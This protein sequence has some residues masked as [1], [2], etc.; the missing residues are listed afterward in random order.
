M[1]NQTNKPFETF[2]TTTGMLPYVDHTSRLIAE[3]IWNYQ[4]ARIDSLMMEYCPDDMTEDQLQEYEKHQK[5][6]KYDITDKT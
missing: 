4:Q 3:Y 1:T 5:P 2:L 6:V